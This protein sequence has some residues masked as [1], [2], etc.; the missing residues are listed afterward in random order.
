MPNFK[1]IMDAN[2]ILMVLGGAFLISFSAV[3]VQLA[4]VPAAGLWTLIVLVIATIQLPVLL[5][6]LPIAIYLFYTSTIFIAVSFL[7]LGIVISIVDT[8]IRA[9]LMGRGGKTPI[10]VIM[11]G[12]IG[13][14]LVFGILGLFVG[15]VILA[16]SYK[17]MMAWL[18][19]E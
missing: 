10:L 4:N 19:A 13:G 12:A 14:M 11:L 9:V 3:W 15:A 5:V 18:N 6:M 2:P 17:L 7:I 1:R 8:P 16:L